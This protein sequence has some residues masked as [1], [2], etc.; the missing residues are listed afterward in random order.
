RQDQYAAAFG[1][2][3]YIRF[4]PDHTVEIEPVPCRRE[5]LDELERR[6]IMLY[7]A[8]QRDANQILQKQ[9]DGTADRMDVLRSMRDLAA[10]MRDVLTG[11][12]NVDEFARLLDRGWELKRSLGFG[13]SSAFLDDW[14]S[15]AREAGA[16]GGKLAGAGGGGFLFLLAPPD[17]HEAIRDALGRPRELDFSI[18]SRGSRIIFISEH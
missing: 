4:L 13:I 3:N 14:Y 11:E 2:L 10:D 6:A 7:T 1:G 17:C 5:T 16:Q 9:S 8:Q 12:G 18:D 15:K